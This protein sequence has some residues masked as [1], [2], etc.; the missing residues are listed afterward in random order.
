VSYFTEEM[1]QLAEFLLLLPY[2]IWASWDI[3]PSFKG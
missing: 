2:F 1:Q 3:N